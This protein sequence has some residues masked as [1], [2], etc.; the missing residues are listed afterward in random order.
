MRSVVD[1]IFGE[2]LVQ[3]QDVGVGIADGLLA[4]PIALGAGQAGRQGR[5]RQ[6]ARQ[7]RAPAWTRGSAVSAVIGMHAV[8]Y[9]SE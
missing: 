5:R 3:H 4:A 7:E 8:L 1:L 2:A 9:D 6:R